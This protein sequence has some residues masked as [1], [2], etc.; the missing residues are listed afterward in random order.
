MGHWLSKGPPPQIK[1]DENEGGMK[2]ALGKDQ[3]GNRDP[4]ARRAQRIH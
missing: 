1:V 2:L 3:L 4:K